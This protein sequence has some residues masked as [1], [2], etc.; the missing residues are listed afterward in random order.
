[1]LSKSDKNITDTIRIFSSHDLT[2]CYLVPTPTGMDKSI[3]DATDQVRNFLFSNKIHNYDLQKQGPENKVKI[4]ASYVYSDKIIPVSISLYRPLT[5]SGDPRIWFAKLNEYAEPYNLLALI[6]HD[7]QLFI[8]NTSKD[9]IL[10]SFD[11]SESPLKKI[12]NLSK[13]EITPTA[14]ELLIKLKDIAKE[15]FIPSVRIGDTGIGATLESMLDIKTNSSKLPDYK[16]IEIKASRLAPSSRFGRNRVTLFSQ[17]PDWKLSKI[18][19][20]ICLLNKYG[21]KNAEG[22]LQL[23]CSLDTKKPNSQNLM[24]K[25]EESKNHLLGV[26]RLNNEDKDL[27]VWLIQKLKDRMLEKHPESFWVKAESKIEKNKEFFRYYKVVHTSRPLISNLDYL[28]ADGTISLDL[29]LSKKTERAVRDHGYLFK[30]W[31]EDFK[32]LFLNP[33]EYDLTK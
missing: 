4:E 8:V 12:S 5:K 6:F 10:K 26:H 19:S 24:L 31:P 2:A 16:G 27:M 25:L 3:M 13:K 22:R 32:G 33:R 21:Y 7:D 28:F 18:E 23:Y 17:I 9:E 14:H 1:M 30:I 29:T 15:G 20:A 11:I